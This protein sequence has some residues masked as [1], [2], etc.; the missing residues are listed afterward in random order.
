MNILSSLINY[1]VFHSGSLLGSVFLNDYL[2]KARN[3]KKTSEKILQKIIRK[4]K[5]TEYG[6]KYGFS[7]IKTIDDF[8]NSVPLSTYDDY[9]ELGGTL[10]E[11]EFSLVERKAQRWLD[12]FT[13]DRCKELKVIPNEVR[14]VLVEF[15]NRLTAYEDQKEAGETIT[16]YS[17]GVEQL[18]FQVKTE[19]ET[20]P[21]KRF[22]NDSVHSDFHYRFLDKA[23]Q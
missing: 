4:N 22:I 17:N 20:K 19:T 15:I 18:S 1:I 12:Y 6:R 10:P 8:R 14:E 23:I 21:K 7:K 9:K 3:G 5:D 11:K 2:K 16:Q 13:F